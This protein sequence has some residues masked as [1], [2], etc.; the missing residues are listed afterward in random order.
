MGGFPRKP[1]E[2]LQGPLGQKKKLRATTPASKLA[3]GP[4]AL[5]RA[6]LIFTIGCAEIRGQAKS[7]G[8]TVRRSWAGKC[9]LPRWWEG[10]SVSTSPS[11]RHAGPV[12]VGGLFSPIKRGGSTPI[13]HT[14]AAIRTISASWRS[15]PLG[16]RGVRTDC[17]GRGE[18][19]P[20]VAGSSQRLTGPDPRPPLATGDCPMLPSSPS[21]RDDAGGLVAEPPSKEERFFS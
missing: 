10:S 13:S 7:E 8:G 12:S 3:G 4:G 14:R 20:E 21:R 16:L 15:S 2:G 19:I 17:I 1:K 11:G 18:S 6:F 5:N 9:C